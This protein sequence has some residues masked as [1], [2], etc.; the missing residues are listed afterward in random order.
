MK[1]AIASTGC[2]Q[3]IIALFVSELGNNQGEIFA[4]KFGLG[5]SHRMT[6]SV[7]RREEAKTWKRGTKLAD[8]ASFPSHVDSRTLEGIREKLHFHGIVES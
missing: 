6:V 1:R 4:K 5:E 3:L 7:E 2:H 8:G